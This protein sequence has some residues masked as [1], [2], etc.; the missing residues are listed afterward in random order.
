MLKDEKLKIEIIRLHHN[1]LVVKHGERWKTMKLM[2]RN[3]QWPRVTKN[4]RKYV[5]KYN[6]GQIIKNRIEVP[7][8]KLMVNE[9][10]EK[11]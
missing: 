8:E 9:I 10:P 2:M 11:L 1:V 3:Y 7:A 5:N 4:V 6:F